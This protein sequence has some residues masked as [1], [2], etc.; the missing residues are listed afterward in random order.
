MLNI[1]SLRSARCVCNTDLYKNYSNFLL[2]SLFKV[3][4]LSTELHNV[5]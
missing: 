5:I 3:S 1:T 4:E 2:I